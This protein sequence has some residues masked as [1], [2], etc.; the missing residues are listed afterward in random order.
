MSSLG[1][2]GSHTTIQEW[3]TVKNASGTVRY[4][5]AF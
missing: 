1:P 2:T 3:F 4:I 5:P